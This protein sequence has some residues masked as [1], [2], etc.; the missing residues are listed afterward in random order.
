MATIEGHPL[1]GS[2]QFSTTDASDGV[3]FA[4]DTY[5]RSAN[6]FDWMAMNTVGAPLQ[7][8]NWKR[9]VQ[10][11]IDLSGGAADK[12]VQSTSEELDDAAAEKAEKTLRSTV[13]ARVRAESAEDIA[14][15]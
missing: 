13:N 7:D 10:R 12:S 2:V 4:I 11:V 8:A 6:F 15:G 9:V 5:T 3:E 1:A 14:Q